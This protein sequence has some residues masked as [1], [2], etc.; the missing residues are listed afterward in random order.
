MKKALKLMLRQLLLE[1]MSMF[2]K[3]AYRQ[4][5]YL[6]SNQLSYGNTNGLNNMSE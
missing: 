4:Y 2:I 1:K 5:Q 6:S 3:E